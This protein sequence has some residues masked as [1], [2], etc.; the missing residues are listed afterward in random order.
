MNKGQLLRL[1]GSLIKASDGGLV[2]NRACFPCSENHREKFVFMRDCV[3]KMY[4]EADFSRSQC[5]QDTTEGKSAE[6]IAMKTK[7][8]SSPTRKAE[9]RELL[10]GKLTDIQAAGEAGYYINI[11]HRDLH[12]KLVYALSQCHDA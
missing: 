5:F 4:E 3:Q 1:I 10:L 7:I 12:E 6:F 11:E 8:H 2:E 9:H